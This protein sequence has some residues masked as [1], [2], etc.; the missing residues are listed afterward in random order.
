MDYRANM[1]KQDRVVRG[2]YLAL[3]DD[4][5]N[6]GIIGRDMRIIY[7]NADGK[8]VCIG[9]AGNHHLTGNRLCCGCSV[10]KSNLGWVKLM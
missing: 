5:A 3:V 10:A 4:G 6:G 1:S 8:Q 7:F 2:R 9:I